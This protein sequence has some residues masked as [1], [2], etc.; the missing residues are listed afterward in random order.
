M[1]VAP[2]KL[3]ALVPPSAGLAP[4]FVERSVS[5]VE[6]PPMPVLLPPTTAAVPL[7]LTARVPPSTMAVLVSEPSRLVPPDG[8]PVVAAEVPP[9]C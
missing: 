1:A 2:P 6:V 3:A 5:E 8:V 4:V 7:S 9:V